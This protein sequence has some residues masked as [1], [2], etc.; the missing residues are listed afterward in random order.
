MDH[1]GHTLRSIKVNSAEVRSP[2]LLNYGVVDLVYC[3]KSGVGDSA[4]DC[5]G[6]DAYGTC[7]ELQ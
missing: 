2:A 7:A 6:R 1:L 5:R 4:H 3:S